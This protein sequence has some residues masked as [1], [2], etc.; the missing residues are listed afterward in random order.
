MKH[1]KS[2]DEMKA[3]QTKVRTR[4]RHIESEIQKECVRLF[5]IFYPRYLIFS[6]PNGGSRNARE[7]AMLSAEGVMPGVSDLVVIAE[8]R[9]LFVEMKAPKGRQSR[10]Q[11][12]FQDAIERLGFK[13]EICRSVSEFLGTIKAWIKEGG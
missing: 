1:W 3:A 2:Y 9:V 10:Y 7:A 8:G 11:K 12:V 4:P 6:V 13:Y 5:R